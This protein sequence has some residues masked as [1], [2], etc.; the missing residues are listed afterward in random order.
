[1][2]H[3]ATMALLAGG[4]GDHD[5]APAASPKRRRAPAEEKNE[6]DGH[7]EQRCDEEPAKKKIKKEVKTEKKMENKK[8]L[9]TKKAVMKEEVREEEDDG[10]DGL[11]QYIIDEDDEDDDDEERSDSDYDEVGLAHGHRRS[12][13]TTTPAAAT[14][15]RKTTSSRRRSSSSSSS[16][17]SSPSS[18]ERR[19]ANPWPSRRRVRPPNYLFLSLI[20]LLLVISFTRVR[21]RLASSKREKWVS[22]VTK[23]RIDCQSCHLML[24]CNHQSQTRL[25]FPKTRHVI[26]LL[27]LLVSYVLIS[28]LPHL[29]YLFDSLPE[30][31]EER[32][33]QEASGA[34]GD[35]G[36]DVPALQ[37]H[38]DARMAHRAR[39][40]GHPL[41]RVRLPGTT[42]RTRHVCGRVVCAVCEFHLR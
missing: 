41:Q 10:D 40:Q 24:T 1:M 13:T 5:Q 31:Q 23:F 15:S 19:P 14:I 20:S 26:C 12:P 8:K 39:G 6:G 11:F 35:D 7:D 18:P 37:R 17:S 21:L 27:S 2:Q 25:N 16:S 28:L 4:S 29:A 38:L 33:R 3:A 22:S 30:P 34:A 42:Y 9:E 32:R 36:P